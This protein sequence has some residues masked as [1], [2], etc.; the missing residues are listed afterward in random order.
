M[1]REACLR[2]LE[3]PDISEQQGPSVCRGELHAQICGNLCCQDDDI[4]RAHNTCALQPSLPRS[5]V[6]IMPDDA[7]AIAVGYKCQ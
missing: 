5:S 3:V 4:L 2:K 6:R 7:L 1:A